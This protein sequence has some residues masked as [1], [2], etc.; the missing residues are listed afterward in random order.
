[1]YGYNMDQ[2][3]R[4]QFY[5]LKFEA[6]HRVFVKQWEIAK[7]TIGKSV[8]FLNYFL[9][10]RISPNGFIFHQYMAGFTQGGK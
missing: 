1:M 9:G 2:N 10:Q 8:I 5:S 4:E 3:P 6:G 7:F